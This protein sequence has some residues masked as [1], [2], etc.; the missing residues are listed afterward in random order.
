MLRR[1]LLDIYSLSKVEILAEGH[2]N[3]F[4]VSADSDLRKLPPGREAL[5]QH[6]KRT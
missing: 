2:I 3:K 4:T 5:T 6:I 1:F